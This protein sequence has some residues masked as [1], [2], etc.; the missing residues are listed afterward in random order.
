VIGP[1]LD[2]LGGQAA[3]SARLVADLQG[4]TDLEAA[5]LPVNPRLPGP[6]RLLQK[7]KYLRTLVTSLRYGAALL[8]NV[9]RYDVLHIFSASYWSF[10]LA[11]TPAL[12]AG[13]LFRK[14]T[15]LNYHSGEAEDH[16]TRW[17]SAKAIIRLADAVA[18]PSGFLVNVI[19]RFGIQA[20]PIFNIVDTARFRFRERRPLRPVFFSNRNLEPM[21]N[22]GCLLRAFATIQARV[23][24]ACLSLA[25]DGSERG[26][27]EQLAER[28]GLKNVKFLGRVPND[29]MPA[30]YDAADIFLNASDIDNM[31]L[32]IIEAFA[33]GTPVVS[34]EAGGI[35]YMVEHEKTG[36]LVRRDD[37]EAMAEQVFRLLDDAL[38]AARIAEEARAECREYE[39]AAVKDQWLTL[40]REL[41]P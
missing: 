10:L 17:K 32:S 3:Q 5:F 36:L 34:T 7:V 40:Y 28:L 14:K 12:L 35:P 11:P 33:A 1:S 18:V 22:V 38:L 27:L 37:H 6:L 21:Y 15:I 30:L 2:I 31:P 24:D 25:G 19:A 4:E 13:R 41:A 23:P 26:A 39:W 8:W 20:R 29:R 16:L 9:P